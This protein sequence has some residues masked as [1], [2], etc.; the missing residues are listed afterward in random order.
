MRSLL[1]QLLDRMP[2]LTLTS[3]VDILLVAVLLY[4]ALVLI[5]GRRAA[6]V[7]SGVGVVLVLYGASVYL[8]LTVLRVILETL[9]PYTAFGIIVMFQSEIRRLLARVGERRLGFDSRLES[10]EVADEIL[11]AVSILAAARTG[12]L[13]VLERKIG[14]RTFIESGVPVDARGHTR[15]AAGHLPPRR[16]H[17]RRSRDRAGRPPGRRR[18]LPAPHHEPG[19]LAQAQHPPSRRSSASLRRP[20]ASPSSS[21]RSAAPSRS[22][23]TVNWRWT[24]RSRLVAQRLG[25]K[26]PPTVAAPPR[27]NPDRGGP[28]M[29]NLLLHNF[30]L[31][32]FCLAVAF[33]VWY[34]FAGARELTMSLP[35][36]VQY[37]NIPKSLEISSSIV[38]QVHLILRGPAP[39]LSRLSPAASPVVLDLGEIRGP[40]QTTFSIDRRNVSL[41]TG[42]ILE[43][44]IPAQIPIPHRAHA[45]TLRARAPAPGACPRRHA[46][47]I[48]PRVA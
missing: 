20:T 29:K 48:G 22:P 47:R 28:A 27:A 1:D 5:R 12:A 32:L 8:G 23:R 46:R 7:L 15:P 39:Q 34:V 36:P 10:R 24:S 3:A 18:L 11:L 43:R 13:I 16:R 4:Q 42:V 44:A 40:G 33:V 38:E 21:A 41:P 17:A 25:R 14:L 9:A 19:A 31:K 26:L 2:Q 6:H 35:V 45:R 37:R 30:W